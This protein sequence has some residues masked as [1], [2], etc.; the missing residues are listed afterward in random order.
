[1]EKNRLYD[2]HVYRDTGQADL[3][4]THHPLPVPPWTHNM[5]S[6]AARVSLRDKY[7]RG[8]KENHDVHV[9]VSYELMTACVQMVGAVLFLEWV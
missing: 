4:Q 3:T 7:I 8:K 2:Q 5:N 6:S 1:M 9:Y